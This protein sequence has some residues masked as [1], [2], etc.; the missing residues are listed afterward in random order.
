MPITA[1]AFP[2][3]ALLF[4]GVTVA[5]GRASS[6]EPNPSGIATAIVLVPILFGTVFAA[7][8]HAE[9][10]AHRFGE[11]Y[12]TLVLTVAV[13][14]IEVALI[15]SVMLGGEGGSPTLARDTV[16]AVVMIVC[17]GL[18]GLCILAGGLRYGEQ[19]FRVR[20]AS[21]YLA[22]L[23]PLSVVTLVLPNYT[24]T[25]FGPIYA[26]SQLAFV[27]FATLALYAAFL[28]VQTVRHRDDFTIGGP[29]SE[30]GH[31]PS[32]RSVGLSTA[33]LIV[34]LTAVILLAKSFAAV[35]DVGLAQVGAPEAAAGVILALVI[36]LP[37]G[38]AA[39]QAARRNEL[40]KSLN[41]ALGSSL[42]TIGLT[43]PAVAAVT[44]A[45]HRDLVLG[46]DGKDTLLLGLTLLISILTFGT[47]RTNILYGF[48][49][50]VVFA[51]FGLL[52]LVP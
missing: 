51:I 7:V 45:L 27:G 42:A 52:V 14:V 16:F 33:L 22:M 13:T 21:A 12:G 50:L 15:V 46:L 5:L 19:G 6:F 2:L 17:N 48:V 20:G 18:V 28:Y 10:L 1:W 29:A 44:L 35:V 11:P 8:H 31:L 43:I 9:I 23:A 49:H 25:A 32:N 41:L 39:V 30:A 4:Y 40:Q 24:R 36:L 37:E 38:V 3:A 47:G 34:A 26:P